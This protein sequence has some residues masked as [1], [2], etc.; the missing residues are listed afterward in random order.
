MKIY[1]VSSEKCK[2]YP[3]VCPHGLLFRVGS[4]ECLI[5]KHNIDGFHDFKDGKDF[6]NCIYPKVTTVKKPHL[7]P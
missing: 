7:R 2:E 1:F 4:F 6:I 5:C 3:T